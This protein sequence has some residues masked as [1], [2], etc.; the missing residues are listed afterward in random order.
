MRIQRRFIDSALATGKL[1]RA[2]IKKFLE[3][4]APIEAKLERDEPLTREEL[5]ELKRI[6]SKYGIT[7]PLGGANENAR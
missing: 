1:N 3:E 5:T 4:L 7:V 2:K 6:E